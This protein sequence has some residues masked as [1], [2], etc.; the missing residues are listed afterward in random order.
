MFQSNADS[1]DQI[2][3]DWARKRD[4]KPVDD[5]VREFAA[6]L[7]SGGRVLDI[8]CGTG[9]PIDVF[10]SESGFTLTGID[11]SEKMIERAQARNLPKA[12]FIHCDFFEFVPEKA[13]DAAIAFDSIWHIPL[14]LQRAIYPRIA[15]WLNP[16]GWFLFTHGRCEGSVSGDMFGAEFH[17]SALNASE[18]RSILSENGFQIESMIENYAHPTTGTRDLLAIARK[19]A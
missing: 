19:K 13:F 2:A 5:C 17:Y 18:L 9:A 3:A 11:A 12:R 8:G 6:R 14:E 15:E 1:Y 4:S 7:P 16:G 10:L